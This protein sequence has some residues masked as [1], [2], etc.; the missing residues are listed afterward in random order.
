MGRFVLMELLGKGIAGAQIT[1]S[2]EHR[3]TCGLGKCA[4]C[5][6]NHLTCCRDGPGLTH[7]RIKAVEK[8]L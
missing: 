1:L 2:L 7:A 3:M 4:H 8:A 6:I 5:Q